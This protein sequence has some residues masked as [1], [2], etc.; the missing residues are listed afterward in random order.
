MSTTKIWNQFSDQI[1]AFIL[2]RVNDED[3]AKDILQEVFIKIHTKL[4]T[5]NDKSSLSSWLFTVTRNTIFDYYR[6]KK[7]R[8]KEQTLIQNNAHLFDDDDI[9]VFCETCLHLFVEELPEKYREAI[10]ATDLGDLS[11]KEYAERIGTSYSGLKSRVQ[12]GRAQLN[13]HFKKCCLSTN[14]KGESDCAHKDK[15]A[16]TC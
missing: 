14:A 15:Y 7:S 1:Y 9:N 5:L 12:R 11:Q 3:I 10:L 8:Q 16:C 6:S 2:S 4:E 13:E